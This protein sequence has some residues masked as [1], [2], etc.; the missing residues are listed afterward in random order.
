MRNQCPGH[1]P[2]TLGRY[3]E[4]DPL[5]RL[6]SGN[7][8]Y[9]YVGDNPTNFIDPLGLLTVY[10]WN[11]TGS[12]NGENW[13]HASILL[14]DGT[15]IS[16]WPNCTEGG[17]GSPFSNVPAYQNR[18]YEQDIHDEGATPNEV[19]QINGLDEAAIE[20]WW[21]KYR[22]DDRNWKTV[23]RNCSS[24]IA[25]GLKA[26]GAP[27]TGNS[28]SHLYWTPADVLQYALDIAAGKQWN[29]RLG[30]MPSTP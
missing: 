20:A 15:Y 9:V 29:D 2:P 26:G 30:N 4:P 7:N 27:D 13:G 19:I 16:W 5:G 6:G 18:N 11:Y 1:L 8:L 12:S 3:I 22:K 14:N 28:S 23:G 25:N 10:I 21:N 17:C 24:T